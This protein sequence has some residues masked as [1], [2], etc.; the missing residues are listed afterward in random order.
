VHGGLGSRSEQLHL[1]NQVY[2]SDSCWGAPGGGLPI[3]PAP[4]VPEVHKNNKL[5]GNLPAIFTGDRS[6]VEECITKWQLYK[7]VT[8]GLAEF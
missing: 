6:M 2:L 7:R 4:Q 5:V 8:K 3:P 1:S